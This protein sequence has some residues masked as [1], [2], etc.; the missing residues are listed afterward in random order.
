MKPPVNSWNENSFTAAKC[1]VT[2]A[3]MSTVIVPRM[4]VILFLSRCVLRVFRQEAPH[5][6]CMRRGAHKIR[7]IA[8][9]KTTRFMPGN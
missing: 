5:E 4:K 9:M 2:A 1:T 8:A 6:K 3:N 7:V